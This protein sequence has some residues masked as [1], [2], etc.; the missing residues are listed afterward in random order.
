MLLLRRLELRLRLGRC[1]AECTSLRISLGSEERLSA[2]DIVIRFSRT[3]PASEAS[4]VCMPCWPP[5][6]ISE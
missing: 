2:T 5:V 3:R 4:I 6:W 1:G